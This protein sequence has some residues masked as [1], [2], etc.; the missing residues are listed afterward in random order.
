MKPKVKL[1]GENG[2]IFNL[3]GIAS[4]ALRK[5]GLK[6]EATAMMDKVFDCD[7][8]DMALLVIQE[9]VEVI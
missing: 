6:D 8:Y 4:S 7:S 2:N 9:Y 3:M 5:A 1:I